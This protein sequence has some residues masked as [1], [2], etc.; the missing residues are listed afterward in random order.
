[1]S[2]IRYSLYYKECLHA[3]AYSSL[4]LADFNNEANNLKI[5][6]SGDIV[7]KIEYRIDDETKHK[8]LNIWEMK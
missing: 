4:S 3:F 8:F 7:Y 6:E 5:I 1:M 2:E